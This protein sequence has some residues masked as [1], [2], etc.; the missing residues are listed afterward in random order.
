MT[1]SPAFGGATV[2]LRRAE[3]HGLNVGA[4]LPRLATGAT[5]GADDLAAVL[6]GRVERWSTA[7]TDPTARPVAGALVAGLIPAPANVSDPEVARAL[8][9]RADLIDRRADELIARAQLSS[10]NWLVWLGEQP[11]D[12]ARRDAWVAAAR[13]VAA[14]RERHAITDPDRPLGDADAH[15]LL[16]SADRVRAGEAIRALRSPSLNAATQPAPARARDRADS[17]DPP[18]TVTTMNRHDVDLVE[19]RRYLVALWKPAAALT[20]LAGATMA[21]RDRPR[22]ARPP[23]WRASRW[24]R[25]PRRGT[26]SPWASGSPGPCTAQSPS[27]GAT[28]SRPPGSPTSTTRRSSPAATSSRSPGRSGRPRPGSECGRSTPPTAESPTTGC[29]PPRPSRKEPSSWYDCPIAARQRFWGIC[30]PASSRRRVATPTPRRDVSR[31]G[32]AGRALERARAQDAAARDVVRE[33]ERITR[34]P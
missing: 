12:P 2:A 14:Y 16:Q 8:H 22:R 31:S 11:D 6:H 32:R 7:R 15:T 24:D 29:R 33:A 18:G 30:R 9:E 4:A 25:R 5:V 27:R 10:A 26:E 19:T 34:Q 28:A 20:S 17:S 21:G 23:A 1:A 13:T 3:A